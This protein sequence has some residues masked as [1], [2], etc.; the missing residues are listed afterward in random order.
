MFSFV[1]IGCSF[2]FVPVGKDLGLFFGNFSVYFAVHKN[3]LCKGSIGLY[4]AQGG[5]RSRFPPFFVFRLEVAR[6]HRFYH[7]NQHICIR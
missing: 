5:R 1:G 3:F 6:W 4:F 2:V 7:T